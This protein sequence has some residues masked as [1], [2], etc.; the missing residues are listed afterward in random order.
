MKER[1][2]TFIEILVVVAILGILTLV[3]YPNIKNTLAV[4]NLDNQARAVLGTFQ[5]AKFQAVRNKLNHR[6][7]FDNSLGYWR[8]YVEEE[9][10]LGVWQEVLG[11]GRK[12]ISNKF[13]VTVNLPS[14]FI[15]FSPL[16][17]A[18]NYSTNQH[19]VTLQSQNL[20]TQGKPSRRIIN[21]FAGGSIQ[22]VRAT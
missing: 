20:L 1:G 17:M 13:T 2:Y 10:N 9:V 8:Y 3:S 12:S 16:G 21:V 11:T 5:Q 18:L 6:V 4:R 22:Y 7:V 15:V 14:N 19:D